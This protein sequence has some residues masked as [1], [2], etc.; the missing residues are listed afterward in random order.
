MCS[1][2]ELHAMWGQAPSPGLDRPQALK[3]F[4][5]EDP[6]QPWHIYFWVAG[7]KRALS[8]PLLAPLPPL[9]VVKLKQIEHTLNEK[10]I[11]QAVN[12]PFLV[13]LEFSFKVGSQRPQTRATAGWRSL[14]VPRAGAQ[15]TTTSGCP[16]RQTH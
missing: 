11:L 5:T 10:R 3:R 13:K 6:A 12:F 9:Q 16:K 14:W 8:H 2:P 1:C 7:K 4:W 15:P